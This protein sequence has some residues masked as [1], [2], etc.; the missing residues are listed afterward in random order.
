MK[1]I[2]S[3]IRFALSIAASLILLCIVI[4][5]LMDSNWL[6]AALETLY[7][8]SSSGRI[9]NYRYALGF[10]FMYC[11]LGRPFIYA[12]NYLE[13]HKKESPKNDKV[14]NYVCGDGDLCIEFYYII[15]HEVFLRL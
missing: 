8:I 10:L 9:S 4:L 12:S 6:H 11:V 1:R 15:R 14:E 2:W 7:G 13:K 3:S 5:L